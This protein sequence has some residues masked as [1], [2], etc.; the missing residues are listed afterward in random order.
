MTGFSLHYQTAEMSKYKVVLSK[1]GF[2]TV[3]AALRH[4]H[5]HI[6]ACNISKAWITLDMEN[7]PVI[8][9]K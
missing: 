5:K 7:K 1:S 8:V 4:Y 3:E 2:L 9:L 6:D